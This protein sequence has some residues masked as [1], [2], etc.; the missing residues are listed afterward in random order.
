MYEHLTKLP[1]QV[2]AF[3]GERRATAKYD[4]CL[5]KAY[6]SGIREGLVTGLGSGAV[7]F[8]MLSTYALAV[9]YGGKMVLEKGY[10]G[11]DV[12]SVIIAVLTGSM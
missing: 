1:T 8:I 11:G 12:I 4:E 10:T 6:G 2:V 7:M 9:W 5:D 3:S